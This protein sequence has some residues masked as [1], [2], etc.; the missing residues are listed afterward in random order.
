M[1]FQGWE[2]PNQKTILGGGGRM[3]IF[4]NHAMENGLILN[5][6]LRAVKFYAFVKEHHLLATIY[7]D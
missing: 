1:E 4:W 6:D 2:G 3:D 5:E 7:G